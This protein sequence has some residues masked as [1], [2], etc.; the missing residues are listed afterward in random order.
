MSLLN[1][2]VLPERPGFIFLR[3]VCLRSLELVGSAKCQTTA[4]RRGAD[5]RGRDG[6]NKPNRIE[7]E[8]KKYKRKQQNT[9]LC[10][11]WQIRHCHPVRVRKSG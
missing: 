5:G 8:A 2:E 4:A 10:Q 11:G 7:K 1:A 6:I 3:A 9:G